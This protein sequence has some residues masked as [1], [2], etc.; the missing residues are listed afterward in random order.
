MRLAAVVLLTALCGGVVASTAMAERPQSVPVPDDTVLFEFPAGLVC[1]EAIAP[2]GIRVTFR[3]G[4]TTDRFFAS[5]RFLETG[6]GAYETLNIATGKTVTFDL[7]G[8]TAIAPVGD[9]FEVKASG[10]LITSFFPG[11]QGPGDVNSGR[12][13]V[14]TGTQRIVAT[15]NFT[16]TE[17]ESV[18]QMTSVCDLLA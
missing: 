13:Y 2:E 12:T 18:G 1:P 10:V 9:G 7:R 11:D 17:F 6:R 15:G 16:I 4:S 3:G 5:G 14:F 8:S